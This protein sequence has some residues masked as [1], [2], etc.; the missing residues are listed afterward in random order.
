MSGDKIARSLSGDRDEALLIKPCAYGSGKGLGL[1]TLNPMKAKCMEPIYSQHF[2]P[3]SVSPTVEMNL[4]SNPICNPSVFCRKYKRAVQL[5]PHDTDRPS[6]FLI[7]YLY[8]VL[9]FLF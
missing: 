4:V 8:V 5:Y 6:W 3:V 1:D 2:M 7:D 9:Q